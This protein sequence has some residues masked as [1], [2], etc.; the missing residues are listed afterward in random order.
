MLGVMK[1]KAQA[2]GGQL[3]SSAAD[4]DITQMSGPIAS[5]MLNAL[6]SLHPKSLDLVDES[7]LHAGHA[8][9][10]GFDGESH[11]KLT[12]VADCFQDLS[13]VKRHQLVYT[14]LKDT[15]PKIHALQISAK[16][17]Q[18]ASGE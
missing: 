5:A 18:E 1:A 9:A 15:M 4:P 13:R 11:F 12:I 16:T 6:Q 8:G 14:L 17:P 10:K 2:L 7:H 3:T